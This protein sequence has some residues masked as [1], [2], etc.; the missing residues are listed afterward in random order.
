MLTSA[1]HQTSANHQ[2]SAS[3]QT[4][5]SHQTRM[6]AASWPLAKAPRKDERRS[7]QGKGHKLGE[8]GPD[9]AGLYERPVVGPEDLP[10]VWK[11]AAGRRRASCAQRQCAPPAAP[12]RPRC[13]HL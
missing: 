6:H 2:T 3:Y 9:E 4:Y 8:G 7:A 1:S 10:K 13:A 5:A 11:H 12:S